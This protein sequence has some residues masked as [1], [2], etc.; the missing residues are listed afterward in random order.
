MKKILLIG[1]ILAVAVVSGC[2]S[3]NV[4]RF[5]SQIDESKVVKVGDNDVS[6]TAFPILTEED[7]KKYFDANLN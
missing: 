4:Q 2:A 6:I 7:S 3:Y 5:P 1:L